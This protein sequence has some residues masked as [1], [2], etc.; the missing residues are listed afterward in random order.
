[1]R[2][3]PIT[4]FRRTFSPMPR[5]SRCVVPPCARKHPRV[6]WIWVN[7]IIGVLA[8]PRSAPRR[9]HASCVGVHRSAAG[10]RLVPCLEAIAT[11]SLATPLGATR[12][13]ILWVPVSRPGR[14]RCAHCV[15]TPRKQDF[16]CLP[17][18]SNRRRS[19]A[20]GPCCSPVAPRWPLAERL[21]GTCPHRGRLSLN[22]RRHP[23]CQCRARWRPTHLRCCAR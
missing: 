23:I 21:S 16:P 22:R 19:P 14:L 6:L 12:S 3:D 13:R 15:P 9:A 4:N 1:M 5:E 10:E 20:V 18:R 2:L 7:T 8:S 11:T 17:H